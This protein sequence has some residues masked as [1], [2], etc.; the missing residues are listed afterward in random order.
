MLDALGIRATHLHRD[1]LRSGLG[2]HPVGVHVGVGLHVDRLLLGLRGVVERHRGLEP[3]LD[4]HVG[5]ARAFVSGED[6]LGTAGEVLDDLR[7]LGVPSQPHDLLVLGLRN[8]VGLPAA[9]VTQ[10]GVGIIVRYVDPGRVDDPQHRVVGAAPHRRIGGVV[11]GQQDELAV[12]EP[13]PH[14]DMATCDL[15]RALGHLLVLGD[16]LLESRVRRRGAARRLGRCRCEAA[17]QG[18]GQGRQGGCASSC[19]RAMFLGHGFLRCEPHPRHRAR[20]SAS[21][22]MR[23]M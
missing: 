7:G 15:G 22:F 11:T 14:V 17:A 21:N 1:R 23:S 2:E 19:Q 4:E 10:E 12:D 18:E 16:G 8:D 20:E 3:I 9:H 5:L 6:Q 13:G